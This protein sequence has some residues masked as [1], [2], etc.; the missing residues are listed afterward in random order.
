MKPSILFVDD[1]NNILQ[2]LRRSLRGLD[3]EWNIHYANGGS[4][5]LNFM[6]ETHVDVVISDT[7]MPGMRGTELLS[8]IRSQY[9]H[10]IRLVL[11]GGC[12]NDDISLLLRT[13]HQFFPKPFDIDKLKATVEHLLR[14]KNKIKNP[15]VQDKVASISKLP[16]SPNIHGRFYKELDNV[17]PDLNELG[18]C[19]SHDVGLTAKLLQSLN[20]TFFGVN[21]AGIHPN[22]AVR[23]MGPGTISHLFLDSMHFETLDESHANYT[24]ISEVYRQSL[25]AALL[26]KEIAKDEGLSSEDQDLAFTA[27]MLHDI[28]VIVLATEMVDEFNEIKSSFTLGSE[29]ELKAEVNAFGNNHCDIGAY[30]LGLWGFPKQLISAVAYHQNPSLDESDAINLTTIAH[31]AQAFAQSNDETTQEAALD[32]NYLESLGI[33]GNISQWRAAHNQVL[34]LPIWQ[35]WRFSDQTNAA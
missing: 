8:E 34:S 31:I 17:A 3:K 29:E 21:K 33:Y 20:S 5:A 25:H 10:T 4:E 6:D 24:V 22:R 9:P 32:K 16:C 18:A 30:F 27:G 26:A 7:N 1:Q 12:R 35:T 2:S 28:G 11:S 19:I 14:L 13:S 23:V 15:K